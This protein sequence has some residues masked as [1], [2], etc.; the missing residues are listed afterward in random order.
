MSDLSAMY[1]EE[2]IESSENEDGMMKRI[3]LNKRVEKIMTEVTSL[4]YDEN[5]NKIYS[6]HSNGD[7]I[8]WA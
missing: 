7:V 4:Y 2:K 3:K 6:G 5:T 1:E 8:T